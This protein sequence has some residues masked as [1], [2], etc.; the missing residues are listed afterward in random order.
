MKRRRQ[1]KRL[2]CFGS[3]DINVWYSHSDNTKTSVVTEKVDY[4]DIVKLNYR[5][6]DFLDDREVVARALQQPNCIEAVI[7]PNGN[8]VIVN[9]ERDSLLRFWRIQRF[10]VCYHPPDGCDCDR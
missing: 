8:K 5:D 1:I 6:P 10:G 7:S 2:K 4:R 3:Y 9:V